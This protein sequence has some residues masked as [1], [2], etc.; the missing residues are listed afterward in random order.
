M[1]KRNALFTLFN[2]NGLEE[3]ARELV[4]NGWTIFSTRGTFQALRNA[5]ISVIDIAEMVG[6]PILGHRVVSLSREIYAGLLAT[7]TPED[8]TELGDRI[9]WIDLVW[10][11][12]YPLTAE[13][14][15]AGSTLE[16]VI[17]STDI[18]G[19]TLLRAAAKGQRYAICDPN[20]WEAVLDCLRG[21]EA[22]RKE[23][24]ERLAGK[25]EAVVAAYALASARYRSGG[26]YDGFIGE[27]VRKLS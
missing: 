19:P 16:S 9:P 27:M 2:K 11:D 5:G 14:A 3:R 12:M 7:D 22:N 26:V 18:G 13:I 8:L 10:V 23:L 20:D 1:N 25:A 21:G 4:N 17:E 24:V 15:K 6:H